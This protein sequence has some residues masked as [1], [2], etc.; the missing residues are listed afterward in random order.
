MKYSLFLK[1]ENTHH[2]FTC[3][4]LRSQPKILNN[5]KHT[6][7]HTRAFIPQNKFNATKLLATYVDNEEEKLLIK[8][9]YNVEYY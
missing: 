5:I 6:H 2:N 4:S 7:T 9:I 3:I 1:K 8:D